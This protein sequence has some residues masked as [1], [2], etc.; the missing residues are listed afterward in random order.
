VRPSSESS[1][2]LLALAALPL[3]LQYPLS[4][5]FNTSDQPLKLR[6]RQLHKQAS[7]MSYLLTDP[8]FSHS[9]HGFMQPVAGAGAKD[10]CIDLGTF[11]VRKQ[12][13]KQRP[14]TNHIRQIVKLHT[15]FAASTAVSRIYINFHGGN[16]IA[17]RLS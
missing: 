5:I 12:G 4:G 6:Y 16:G 8:H 1:D 10:V 2:L 9:S 7:I 15:I 14:G 13:G 17:G 11:Y 3:S